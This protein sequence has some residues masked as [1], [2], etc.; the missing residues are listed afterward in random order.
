MIQ[1]LLGER[2]WEQRP[3]TRPLSRHRIGAQWGRPLT[4]IDRSLPLCHPL[5]SSI[6]RLHRQARQLSHSERS[7]EHRT[8]VMSTWVRDEDAPCCAT[9]LVRFSLLTRR[10]HCRRDGQVV[11]GDC[12]RVRVM[13]PAADGTPAAP[14][15]ST[16]AR[17]LSD[18]AGPA[19]L[20]VECVCDL[21]SEWEGI[22]LEPV[23]EFIRQQLRSSS[24][25]D[26]RLQLEVQ[27]QV[28]R[29]RMQQ[30]EQK[31][32]EASHAASSQADSTADSES[33]LEKSAKPSSRSPSPISADAVVAATLSEQPALPAADASVA[34]PLPFADQ[35]RLYASQLQSLQQSLT[36]LHL[37]EGLMLQV[38]FSNINSNAPGQVWNDQT[39]STENS[40]A[41]GSGDD[42]SGS[43]LNAGLY[44]Y[45][46]ILPAPHRLICLTSLLFPAT[47]S[48]FSK[49]PLGSRGSTQALIQNKLSEF[50]LPPHMLDAGIETARGWFNAIAGNSSPEKEKA[51]AAAAAAAAAEKR[52]TAAAGQGSRTGSRTGSAKTSRR[53][54]LK[55]DTEASASAAASAAASGATT[56]PVSAIDLSTVDPSTSSAPSSPN[57]ATAAAADP[58]A[59]AA[60]V[61]AA[62]PVAASTK[63]NS[64]PRIR[65]YSVRSLDSISSIRALEFRP[66]IT[67]ASSSSS[68]SS[69]SAPSSA[70]SAPPPLPVVHRGF[71]ISFHPHSSPC[72]SAALM[73]CITNRRD[74]HVMALY[75][76][77]WNCIVVDATAQSQRKKLQKAVQEKLKEMGVE[78]NEPV[79]GVTPA[80]AAAVASLGPLPNSSML[81]MEQMTL[82]P[83]HASGYSLGCGNEALWSDMS[84]CTNSLCFSPKYTNALSESS[85][86]PLKSVVGFVPWN[87]SN[88]HCSETGPG[89]GG[90][91]ISPGDWERPRP[92]A[93]GEAG[94]WR[95]GA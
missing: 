25:S 19:R 42:N 85:P 43:S 72:T 49:P 18:A 78:G 6:H 94:D 48:A 65:F 64:G 24:I 8:R 2:A 87:P 40:G 69:S 36:E 70:P 54:S 31:Y 81:T 51:T 73:D 86:T 93:I 50:N 61:A 13:M 14:P 67:R 9:C 68:S 39:T 4:P 92:G 5:L 57:P 46:L 90:A 29:T 44:R 26:E 56:P 95:T 47:P 89:N 84:T 59:S 1:R 63:N 38:I 74:D 55:A 34:P 27:L 80:P 52:A 30:Q 66:P 16:A 33:I 22:E 3:R 10:H 32:F 82:I 45:L 15:P 79:P 23:H 17:L 76:N 12:S 77:K 11:C 21:T 91:C 71:Q 83:A 60:A 62:E 37:R 20:C 35:M 58:V 88:F 75:K 41:A 53:Q 28:L 7:A